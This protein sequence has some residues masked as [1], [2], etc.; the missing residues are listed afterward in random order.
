M[1]TGGNWN[2]APPGKYNANNVTVPV[3][4]AQ[5]G[6]GATTASITSFNNITGYS[7]S[8]TTGT[9]STNLVFSTSPTFI[10][11]VLGTPTSGTL[12]NCTGLP[13]A[14]GGTG[15][16]SAT[17][18]A[19]LCGGTT[20]TGALQSISGVGTS[21]QILTSNGAGTLPTMQ[22]AG[23]TYISTGTAS[24]S[25]T[26]D[27]TNLSNTYSSY[28]FVLN[29]ILPATDNVGLIFRTST[30]NGSSYDSG[31]TDYKYAISTVNDAGVY[32]AVFST[33]DSSGALTSTNIGNAAGRFCD[34]TVQL[35]LPSD[36]SNCRA[37]VN[38]AHINNTGVFKICTGAAERHTAADVDAIRFLMTSGNIASG[39][40]T[41]YGVSPS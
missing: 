22:I 39:T 5:G 2:L 35:F 37:Y 1:P 34:A 33:G 9:T 17:A 38:L 6:T 11:P 4:V 13:V 28:L 7:A 29:K 36:A 16:A 15:L 8:G 40:I 31:A 10:T 19:V 14:G 24:S 41:L 30:N 25:A 3:T 32:S 21:K 12:T 18:Y 20:S 26:L 23:L 27:F